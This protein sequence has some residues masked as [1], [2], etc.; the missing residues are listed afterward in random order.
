MEHNDASV[1]GE[2]LIVG[3]IVCCILMG[4]SCLS[5]TVP[6]NLLLPAGMQSISPQE[7]SE[8][9]EGTLVEI[10]TIP[11]GNGIQL[12]SLDESSG[13]SSYEIVGTVL[14]ARVDRLEMINC[15]RKRKSHAPHPLL[16]QI[17]IVQRYFKTT[18]TM[19]DFVPLMSLPSHE[20]ASADIVLESPISFRGP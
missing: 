16:E 17:P 5:E 18:S 1:I 20:I 19:P 10:T 6:A 7:V 11:E 13:R 14:R 8:L 2:G 9:M 12:F 15:E 4:L 3:E